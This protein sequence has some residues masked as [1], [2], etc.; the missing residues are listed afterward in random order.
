MGSLNAGAYDQAQ[1]AIKNNGEITGGMDNTAYGEGSRLEFVNDKE[2]RIT[3]GMDNGVSEKGELVFTNNGT[4]SGKD[5][6]NGAF[7]GG[8]LKNTN[9][10]TMNVTN[11]RLHNYARG[12]GSFV[13]STNNGTING[14]VMN[15]A[16]HEG[17]RNVAANNGTVN[18]QYEFYTGGGG[19]VSATDPLR[20]VPV[21]V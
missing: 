1:A 15:Q 14:G 5:L 12:G 21:P 7:D 2:G 11:D 8:V 18:G 6:F 16:D 4:I 10:G 9:N 19:E 3:G 17:S 20:P 13:E